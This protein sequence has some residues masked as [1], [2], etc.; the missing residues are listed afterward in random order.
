MLWIAGGKHWVREKLKHSRK[1]LWHQRWWGLWPQRRCMMNL[2]HYW[3]VSE[4]FFYSEHWNMFQ[5][6]KT[7]LIR[8]CQKRGKK[9]LILQS[10]YFYFLSFLK[11][12]VFFFVWVCVCV[13]FFF[14][15]FGQLKWASGTW[16]GNPWFHNFPRF[17][18]FLNNI[19]E[20]Y[21]LI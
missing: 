9:K 8:F 15:F 12:E 4:G 11:V 21:I 13:C 10:F 16:E 17:S 6:I 7:A 3:S 1:R 5:T 14:F 18:S 2:Q 19:W 20:L